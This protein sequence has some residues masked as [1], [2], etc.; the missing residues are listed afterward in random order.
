MTTLPPEGA[1][2]TRPSPARLYDYYLGGKDNYP[3]DRHVGDSLLEQ[4][5][6]LGSMARANRAWLRRVVGFMA[7]QGI[8]QFLDLGSGLPAQDP[9]HQVA[10]SVHPDARVVYVDHDPLAI[11]HANALLATDPERTTVVGVDMRDPH[12][13]LDHPHTRR[14]IDFDRPVGL[15]FVAVLHFLPDSVHPHQIVRT[16]RDALE[17]GSCMAISHVDNETA[18]ERAALLEQVYASTSAAGQARGRAEIEAFFDGTELVSPGLTY[19]SDWRRELHDTSWSP[20][21]A[22]VLGGV[23][24]L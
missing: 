7:R 6:E 10:Q 14:L 18:P 8:D 15:L 16:Y 13:V 12:A 2:T 20:A 19:V 17:P 3:A 23:G 4:I 24:R 5:P 21:Q 22:W 1:D 11:A 9:T